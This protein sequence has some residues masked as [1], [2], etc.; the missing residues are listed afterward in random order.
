MKTKLL[1]TL[2]PAVISLSSVAFGNES[3]SLTS[4]GNAQIRRSGEMMA[5]SQENFKP[6][7][8]IQVG[9]E[10]FLLSKGLSKMQLGGG[11]VLRVVD[12]MGR[13]RLY[14]GAIKI[15]KSSDLVIT[16]DGFQFSFWGA[17][18]WIGVED[19]AIRIEVESGI[20][21]VFGS[22]QIQRLNAG[23][24]VLWSKGECLR[25][26]HSRLHEKLNPLNLVDAKKWLELP[27]SQLQKRADHLSQLRLDAPK[28]SREAVL[29]TL[30]I[31]NKY[32]WRDLL[33]K[34]RELLLAQE[35][36]GLA[37]D[38]PILPP[39]LRRHFLE[40]AKTDQMFDALMLWEQQLKSF[41]E[42]DRRYVAFFVRQALAE[43]LMSKNRTSVAWSGK[44][45]ATA[46]HNS[47]V[48]ETAD[49]LTVVSERAGQSLSSSLRLDYAGRRMDWGTPTVE[50]NYL[51][52]TFFDRSFEDREY[53]QASVKPKAT[54]EIS[55]KNSPISKVSPGINVG[56]EFVNSSQGR[57]FQVMS[58][59]PQVEVVFKPKK[60]LGRLSDFLL[61][62]CTI[63]YEWR[64]YLDGQN[65]DAQRRNKDTYS[66][67]VS[68]VLVNMVK[69]GEWTCR[70]TMVLSVKDGD[71][72][73][74]L[75][76]QFSWS[77]D[78]SV[79]FS[80][81][82]WGIKPSYA[83]REKSYSNGRDDRKTEWGSLL[84]RR[85]A[86]ESL[87]FQLGYRRTAQRSDLSAM[88]FADHQFSLGVNWGF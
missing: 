59:A 1:L 7:D 40:N 57:N 49:G 84:T 42:E 20:V 37:N 48:N 80:K 70:E 35:L 82:N 5:A 79:E 34:G 54:Y 85:V 14:Q 39:E 61:G 78:L 15:E 2:A 26:N 36:M 4:S 31:I 75:Q 69:L 46:L 10:P 60:E 88:T 52:K 24:D 12:E 22:T 83:Y 87:E 76:D 71:S 55:S 50:F 74:V 13:F 62:F 56:S 8:L 43:E 72:E 65:L 21:D 67:F 3:W 19:S 11:S 30:S 32:H 6:E 25:S 38:V 29:E 63:G 77:T 47:N 16:V 58:Y 53:S 9:S 41:N 45:R 23:D 28:S 68:G 27:V 17:T 44:V 66:P 33:E 86:S 18:A 73:A 64:D 81:G 51:D